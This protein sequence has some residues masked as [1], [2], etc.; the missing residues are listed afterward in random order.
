LI[1][2]NLIFKTRKRLTDLISQQKFEE[3]VVIG[4]KLI[5]IQEIHKCSLATEYYED[6]F[7]I[8]YCF[9][10][11]N[12]P[13]EALKYYKKVL[14][15]PKKSGENRK[16]ISIATTNLAVAYNKLSEHEKAMELHKKINRAYVKS[17]EMSDQ[18]LKNLYNIGNTY[19][20]M[21]NY[22]GGIIY[23]L[24]AKDEQSINNINIDKKFL[25]DICNS[26]CYCYEEMGDIQKAIEYSLMGL[27]IDI[28]DKR[29]LITNN[30]YL[31][32]LYD[33]AKNLDLALK[34]FCV[35]SELISEEIG[36]DHYTYSI[37]QDL[38]AKVYSKQGNDKE[39]LEL[40]LKNLDRLKR[41]VGE[42]HINYANCLKS[43]GIGYKN[44][45]NISLAEK[46]LIKSIEI[47]DALLGENNHFSIKDKIIL[48]SIY[49][50]MLEYE[51]G[52]SLITKTLGNIDLSDEKLDEV[53]K[54]LI[55]I[56]L[57]LFQDGNIKKFYKDENNIKMIDDLIK[58]T[59]NEFY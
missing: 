13:T 44:T 31:G 18:Y 21:E 58:K 19:F 11:I 23:L 4:H 49:M 9:E 6:L 2:Y 24:K 42:N 3:A 39:A 56:Y 29:E 59:T 1:D 5:K 34:F 37:C 26:I 25:L 35:A 50:E 30:F 54:E 48:G 46:F 32:V 22:E 7:N 51:K 16:I 55:N 17:K 10:K 52:A 20:E 43:I 41:T 47:K 8:G 15:A 53:I 14:K 27:E 12:R 28:L 40:N 36:K 33:K 45:D 57:S 38:I